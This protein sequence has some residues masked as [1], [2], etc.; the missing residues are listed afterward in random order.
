MSSDC[1]LSTQIL[2]DILALENSIKMFEKLIEDCPDHANDCHFCYL[3]NKSIEATE[4][5][6][7]ASLDTLRGI[8]A[9]D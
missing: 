8:E 5:A 3:A 2:N 4:L 6:V 7:R 1:I 9:Y